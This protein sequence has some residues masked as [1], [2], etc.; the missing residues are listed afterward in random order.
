MSQG[1]ADCR[2]QEGLEGA[3]EAKAKQVMI[4]QGII[5]AHPPD[6]HMKP[7]TRETL[8]SC[9]FEA[10]CVHTVYNKGLSFGLG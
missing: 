10:A 2:A 6:L 3:K 7:N 8:N 9:M 5:S 1:L 4:E